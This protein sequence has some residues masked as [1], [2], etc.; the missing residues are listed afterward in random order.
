MVVENVHEKT[1]LKQSKWLEKLIS[2]NKQKRIQA[3]NDFEKDFYKLLNNALYKK[4]MENVKNR[5]K[6]EF[7][8]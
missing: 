5:M 4:T 6:V 7:I 1:S 2:L 3:V 8:E